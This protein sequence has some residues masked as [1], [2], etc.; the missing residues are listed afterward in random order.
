MTQDIEVMKELLKSAKERTAIG[1]Q[2]AM[3]H[4]GRI[5]ALTHAIAVL[6]RIDE[7]KI[8]SIISVIVAFGCETGETTQTMIDKQ[9]KELVTYLEGGKG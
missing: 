8:K 2:V 1:S 4:S 3:G 9:A 6:E 5:E 7:E